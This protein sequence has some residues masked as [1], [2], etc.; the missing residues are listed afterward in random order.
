MSREL[1]DARIGGVSKDR[2]HGSMATKKSRKLRG[3]DPWCLEFAPECSAVV[4]TL[5]AVSWPDS[6]HVESQLR[7]ERINFTELTVHSDGRDLQYRALDLKS[8]GFNIHKHDLLV[9]LIRTH[10][11][12]FL[13]ERQ[14]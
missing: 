4:C 10:C 14:H 7:L 13:H 9:R 8:C 1:S 11:R 3:H 5:C 12:P 6:P 2:V